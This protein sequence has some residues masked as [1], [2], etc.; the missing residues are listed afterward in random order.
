MLAAGGFLRTLRQ[1]Y[2]EARVTLIASGGA[3]GLLA[4]SGLA[5]ALLDSDRA[6]AAWLFGRGGEPPE[7]LLAACRGALVVAFLSDADGAVRENLARLGAARVAIRPPR[8]SDEN[9][10][11]IYAHL[12]AALPETACLPSEAPE[13][14][15]DPGFAAKVRAKLGLAEGEYAVLHPGS[16]S[17]RKNWPAERFAQLGAELAGRVRVVFTFG[18]ADDAAAT[19]V[20]R[21]CPQAVMVRQPPLRELAA[22]LAGARLYVGNDS[23]VTHLACAAGIPGLRPPRRLALFGPTGPGGWAPRGARVLLSP[24]GTMA[25]LEFSAVAAACGEELAG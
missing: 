15:V 11:H 4:E 19:V 25:G 10:I 3:G 9:L 6:E 24:D 14:R 23:G 12:A 18:E 22:I 20:A 17:L 1:V 13:I 16:G 2:P 8:Q 7:R 5:D 21:A